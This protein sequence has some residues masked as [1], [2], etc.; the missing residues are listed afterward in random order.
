MY[1]NKLLFPATD[2]HGKYSE[3][4]QLASMA[5]RLGSPPLDLL[6]KAKQKQ[7]Y[8]PKIWEAATKSPERSFEASAQYLDDAERDLFCKFIRKMVQ[9]SP[10][11]RQTAK[12]LLDDPWLNS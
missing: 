12:Q 1:Q 4:I 9:W 8:H 6:F 7:K 3:E 11:R 5:A 2:E 10:E